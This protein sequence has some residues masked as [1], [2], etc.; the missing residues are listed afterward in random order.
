MIMIIYAGAQ[1]MLSGWDEEKIKKWKSSLL[2]IFIGIF[3]L[4]V[5]YLI[6]T[7]FLPTGG[8]VKF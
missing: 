1:I 4:T 3:I 2:Y 5:N 8:I 7:F 6:I